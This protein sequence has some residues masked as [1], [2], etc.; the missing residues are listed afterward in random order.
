MTPQ[1]NH[2][3]Q[4]HKMTC[5][6]DLPNFLVELP[7][8]KGEVEFDNWIFQVKNLRK[9]Y[10]D[11]AIRNGV[12]SSV[13]GVANKVVRAVGYEATLAE[14]IECLD[15]KFGLARPKTSCCRSSISC[16]RESTN[17]S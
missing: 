3:A 5:N 7:M 6:P 2:E 15:L 1:C 10:T 9:T 11:D 16:T 8:P 13:Q 17:T 4:P 12:V 14:I